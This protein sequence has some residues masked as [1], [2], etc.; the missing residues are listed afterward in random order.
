MFSSYRPCETESRLS[1]RANGSAAEASR[2]AAAAAR[3]RLA[4]GK[5]EALLG[6]SDDEP[7]LLGPG[8]QLDLPLR[9]WW[10]SELRYAVRCADGQSLGF[11]LWFGAAAES[12]GDEG[13]GRTER[14]SE[15]DGVEYAGGAN[16]AGRR[17]LL[18]LTVEGELHGTARLDTGSALVRLHN[19]AAWFSTACVHIRLRLVP[20][21]AA[22]SRAAAAAGSVE[23]GRGIAAAGEEEAA[24]EARL[25][26]AYAT[27]LRA[28]E[29][30]LVERVREL[31]LRLAAAED[32]L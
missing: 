32:E 7:L 9:I 28:D 22:A 19:L 20:L 31:R 16:A 6:T 27:R 29:A 8:Q 1:L 5:Q 15:E 18:G 11:E 17:K 23:G 25:R 10:P 12:D 30:Q 26:A 2:R 3:L 4:S 21:G 14:A 13:G 24:E